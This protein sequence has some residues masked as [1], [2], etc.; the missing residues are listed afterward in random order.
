[1]ICT[2]KEIAII[3]T[4]LNIGIT[5]IDHQNRQYTYNATQRRVLATIVVMEKP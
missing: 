2:D 4:D 3:G 1:M 5:N